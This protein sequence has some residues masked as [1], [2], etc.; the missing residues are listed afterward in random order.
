METLNNTDA[1]VYDFLQRELA[2]GKNWVVYPADTPVN[3]KD[4][5]CFSNQQ[6]AQQYEHDN[7]TPFD[8]MVAKPISEFLGETQLE[9]FLNNNH[10]ENQNLDFLKSN[11]LNLGFGD[12]L[13]QDLEKNI[14]EQKTSF[15]LKHEVPHF[16]NKM[17][18]TLH[19]KKSDTS[20]M[21]FFN[22]YDA[23]LQNGKP[24][25]NKNQAFYIN[26]GMGVTAKES[27]NLLE[28]RSVFKDLVNKEGQKYSAWLKLDFENADEKGNHK[29]KQYSDG[30]GFNLERTLANFPV[31]E[32]QDPEQKNQLLKSLQKGNAQQVT[33]TKDGKGGKFYIEAVPQ[34]KTINVYDQKMHMVKRQNFQES[35]SVKGE[36][37]KTNQKRSE[38]QKA[39][40]DTEDGKPKQRQSRKR[41]LTV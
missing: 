11:L 36:S 13:N 15:E 31:K 35:N 14:K 38:S 8:K 41:K 1:A 21:Y 39:N 26:K 33:L 17:S 2:N 4:L 23:A 25:E 18:Y 28:G 32:L 27:F 19:F 34:F 37:A 12:K 29:L 10:M 22:K 24:E 7:T 3:T 5:H 9:T 40:K 20:D 6:H 30:Y 16:N